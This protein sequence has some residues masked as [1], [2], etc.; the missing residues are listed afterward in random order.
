[1]DHASFLSPT[2]LNTSV[3]RIIISPGILHLSGR[4]GHRFQNELF[5]TGISL[6]LRLD[7]VSVD[8]VLARG[9][10]WVKT[11][12]GKTVYNLEQAR[13]APTL[14]ISFIDG[15]LKTK[16]IGKKNDLQGDLFDLL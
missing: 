6:S 7:S 9:F 11:G 12:R 15:K 1:M 10:A 13:Q 3:H 8:S 4:I 16:P 2:T 5:E 14:E